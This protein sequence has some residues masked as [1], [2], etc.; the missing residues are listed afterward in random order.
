VLS[1]SETLLL[2]GEMLTTRV[3]VAPPDKQ[4]CDQ[5]RRGTHGRPGN[6]NK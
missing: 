4:G 5:G 6:A 1:V 2:D 3:T